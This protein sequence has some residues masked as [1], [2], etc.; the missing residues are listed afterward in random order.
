MKNPEMNEMSSN[1][2]KWNEIYSEGSIHEKPSRE[3]VNLVPRLKSDGVVEILDAGCGTGR[4]SNYLADQG[5]K[6]HGIDVSSEAVKIAEA[7]KQNDAV[8]YSVGSLID[9]PFSSNS[10]D[11]ILANHSLEYA[12]DEDVRKSVKKLDAV[13]KSGKPIFIRVASTQHPFYKAKPADIYGFSHIGFCIKNGLPVHFFEEDE[14]KDLFTNY[15]IE[16]LEHIVHEVDHRKIS[17]PLR[18]WVLFGYKE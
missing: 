15:K 5:F 9:L 11:F 2:S 13:L 1:L 18:E 7:N 12:S 14:L 6:V 10:M 17:V 4:H 8:D 3:I 16:R